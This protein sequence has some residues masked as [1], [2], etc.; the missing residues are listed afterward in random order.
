MRTTT[1]L[2]EQGD[3]TIAWDDDADKKMRDVIQ[4]KMDQGVTFFIIEPRLGGLIPPKK[5]K[6]TRVNQLKTNTRS[7]AVRDEDFA[8]VILAGDAV[9]VKNDDQSPITTKRVAKSAAEAASSNTVAVR[10]RRGG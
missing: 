6:I 10:P 3:V 8:Q 2:N 5:T 4:K 1:I 7:V 9:A